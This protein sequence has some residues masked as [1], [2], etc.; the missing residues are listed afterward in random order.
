VPKVNQRGIVCPCGGAL[1]VAKTIREDHRIRRHK[2]CRKCKKRLT[3]IETIVGEAM[4]GL[5][6][7]ISI[8]FLLQKLGVIAPLS[9]TAGNIY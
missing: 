6:Q 5:D 1:A 8:G 2:R 9:R 4:G 3:T 7:S